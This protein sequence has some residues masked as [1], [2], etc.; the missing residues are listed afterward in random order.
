MQTRLDAIEKRY[1]AQFTALDTQV[2]SML[3]TS[4]YLTQQFAALTTSTK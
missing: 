3:A 2:S 1:R 4:S